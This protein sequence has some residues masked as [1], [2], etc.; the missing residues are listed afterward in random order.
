M[1]FCK[2]ESLGNDFI[3][4]GSP[5]NSSLPNSNLIKRICNRHYGIGADCAIC[6]TSANDADFAMHVYNPD[7]FEAEICGN[8]L[9][10]SAKYVV[11]SGFFKK[12]FFSVSTNSGIRSLKVENRYITAEIG[13]PVVLEDGI[14]EVCG[15]VFRYYN[16]SLG[17]PHCVIFTNT[18]SDDL[19]LFY[20]KAIENHP[21]FPNGTNVEFARVIRDDEIRMRVWER[22]SG[23]TMACGTGACASAAAAVSE[24][25]CEFGQDISVRLDGGVLTIQVASDYSVIM[26]GPA[27]FVYEGEIV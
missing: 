14:L 22:G 16:V 13:R 2:M 25:L 20:G 17:N 21:L 24:G 18:L 27:E 7:G 8:A 12:R 11:D 6:I 23:V 3:L 5:T 4:F 10:C 1:K 19:I 26:T 15:K 9:R